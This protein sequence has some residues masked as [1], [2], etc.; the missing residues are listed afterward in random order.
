MGTWQEKNYSHRT[1]IK[2][3]V[4]NYFD[5]GEDDQGVVGDGGLSA[6]KGHRKIAVKGGNASDMFHHR[7]DNH[8]V[9]SSP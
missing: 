8:H 1:S 2:S 6:F 7:R 3:D 5:Y 4:W 9:C